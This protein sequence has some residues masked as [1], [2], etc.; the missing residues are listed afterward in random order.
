[1]LANKERVVA[2]LGPTCTGK[3][4]LGEGLAA[5][6][7]GEIV[8]ADSMQV[9][10]YFNIGTAKPSDEAQART[11]HHLINVVE[12]SEHFDVARFKELA[13]SAIKDVWSRGKVPIIV[14]GSG[15]YLRVLFHGIFPIPSNEEIRADL[16]ER[17]VR[18]PNDVYEELKKV[19]PTYALRISH[20]D[21]VRVV[22]ALEVFRISGKSMSEWEAGHGFREE[23]YQVCRIGLTQERQK[24]YQRINTRVE[25]MLAAGWV[26]EVKT[27]LVAGHD[28]SCK[29]FSSIGYREILLYLTNSV[30]YA[31]MVTRIK[32]ETR[33]YAKRQSTWFSKG[34]EDSILWFRYPEDRTGI[35]EQVAKF[36]RASV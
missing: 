7:G 4:E 1:M 33:R 25:G 21:R 10:R 24:L 27:I 5:D 18:N 15:L 17:Y 8:N 9:Y 36:L 30:G 20:R 35:W 29:P 12:P 22:R 31:D 11:R 34:E 3:S 28:A 23:R 13:D 6:F 32:Q 26:E 2:V 19:D 14:G 16:Q